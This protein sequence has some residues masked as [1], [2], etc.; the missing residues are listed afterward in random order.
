[1]ELETPAINDLIGLLPPLFVVGVVS[2]SDTSSTSAY[3]DS[4]AT[5]TSTN[6]LRLGMCKWVVDHHQDRILV[7]YASNTTLTSYP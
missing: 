2:L 5:R 1:M 4:I 3:I 6:G 7:C